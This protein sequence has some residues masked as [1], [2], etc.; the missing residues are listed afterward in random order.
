MV[1]T[2]IAVA[3]MDLQRRNAIGMYRQPTNGERL[4]LLFTKK[5]YIG[6]YPQLKQTILAVV[7][8]MLSMYVWSDVIEGLKD[9]QIDITH[10]DNISITTKVGILVTTPMVEAEM[11]PT[12]PIEELSQENVSVSHSVGMIEKYFPEEPQIALAVARAESG[13]N[14]LAVG[15]INSNG[16]QDFGMFQINSVHNPTEKQK[17]NAEENIKLA[18]KIYERSGWGAWSAYNNGKYL[19]FL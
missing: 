6:N 4:K 18:R 13:M 10:K 1:K 2:K 8:I 12:E 15:K 11:L 17:F 5:R 19:K 7:L 14:P 3:T 16:T 9:Y